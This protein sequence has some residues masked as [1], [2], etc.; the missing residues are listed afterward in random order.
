MKIA[1]ANVRSLNTSFQLVE[2]TCLRQNIQLSGLTEIWHP[3]NEVK[4]SVKQKWKWIATERDENRGGGAALMISKHVKV[5][6]RKE[7]RREKIEAVWCNVYS[8]QGSF[9]VGS[10]YIPPNDSKSLKVLFGILEKLRNESLPIM[11]IGDFNAHHPYWFDSSANKLGNEL[12]EFIVDKDLVVLNTAEPTRKD[13]IIDL[14]IVSTSFSD[15]ISNWKVQQEVYLNTDHNL[16]TFNIGEEEPEKSIEKLDFRNADWVKFEKECSE[17]IEGW[18]ETRS[19]N[20]DVNEDYRSFVDLIHKTVQECVPKKRIC[21]HSKGWW[22]PRLT[23]L[24]KDFKKAK[25]MFKKRK[26]ESNEN[27]MKELMKLFK[28][29]EVSAKSKYLDEMIGMLD[30]KKPGEFWKVVNRVK[31]DDVKGVV[32]PI[33]R[34]D[35]SLAVTDEEMKGRY[36]KE[37]LD[38]NNYDEDWYNMVEKEVKNRLMTEESKIKDPQFG[39]Q[40]GFENSDIIIKEVEAAIAV[41][42]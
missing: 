39:E 29:E 4:E 35:G 16:V 23:Q 31:K 5:Y 6:E 32:Q 24:S 10:V 41:S 33:K 3:D 22:S 36:G 15:K 20:T 13:R 27:K 37:T 21:R 7:F 8:N 28:E 40:C 1:Y 19:V 18:L 30:P 42:S 34:D 38:V 11:L 26:D 12:H 17:S 9:V 25:R 2:A 14:T